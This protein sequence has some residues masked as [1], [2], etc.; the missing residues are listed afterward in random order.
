MTE[1]AEKARLPY[2]ATELKEVK[3]KY[4]VYG[5]IIA[6]VIEFFGLGIYW[7]ATLLGKEEAPVR[8]VRILKYSELGPPPSIQGASAAV[9]PSVS[10]AAPMAKPSV[11]IPVPVP[12]AEVS[13]EQS[14]ASQTEMSSVT[15]PVGEGAGTG[16]GQVI[17]QDVNVEN[18]DEEEAPPPDFV[19]FEKEPQVIKRIE[20]VY[21]EL[22]RKAGL[23]GTVWVK[24]W[25]DKEGK[26]K[27]VVILKSASEIFNQ[28][29]I[30]AAKQWIFTP[31][32]MKT[33]P[34]S[35]WISLSFNFKLN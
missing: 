23:E 18:I 2:G 10:A 14:F 4:M 19:P 13:P 21:P 28:P 27:D 8:T 5:L 16:G 12:D 33:G 35:V 22:A 34:V 25:V 32:M 3:Q 20:P 9:A 7:A 11:G 1:L 26:V 6:S 24:L 29:A 31:A 17:E 15:G 30:D